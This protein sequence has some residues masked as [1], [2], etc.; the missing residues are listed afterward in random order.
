M[1]VVIWSSV[2]QL[3]SLS[4]LGP[5]VGIKKGLQEVSEM[6]MNGKSP[7]QAGITLSFSLLLPLIN[8]YPEQLLVPFWTPT[9]VFPP[10][11]AALRAVLP[12]AQAGKHR[13]LPLW[14]RS[15][16]KRYLGRMQRTSLYVMSWGGVAARVGQGHCPSCCST[17]IYLCA[18]DHSCW[19]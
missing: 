4:L 9:I 19:K 11:L 10:I 17:S 2:C 1:A 14:I 8:P 6:E 3:V 13:V 15:C 16:E 12:Q 5:F 7:S 18:G